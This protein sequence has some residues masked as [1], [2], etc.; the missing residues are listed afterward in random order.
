MITTLALPVFALASLPI[1][2]ESPSPAEPSPKV[3][4][5]IKAEN[6]LAI[7][8]YRLLDDGPGNLVCSP[9]SVARVLGMLRE[10][11]EGATAQE[12]E[13]LLA[14]APNDGPD[15]FRALNATI[16]PP[17]AHKRDAGPAYA[18]ESGAA[19][20]VDQR[21]ELVPDG[22]ERLRSGFDSRAETV[23]FRSP[24]VVRGAVND[25][26]REL[27]HGHVPE[28]L[29]PDL[30]PEDGRAILTDAV[31]FRASWSDPFKTEATQPAPFLR[32][33]ATPVDVP[34][35]RRTGDMPYAETE[36]AQVVAIPFQRALVDLIVVLP[37]QGV[38]LGDVAAHEDFT[39]WTG[40]L[41][42]TKVALKL[43][44]FAARMQK[45][46]KV[47]LQTLGVQAAF[48]PAKS[49]FTRLVSNEPLVI[50]AV[51]HGAR[52]VVDENGA[53]AAAA[54]AAVMKVGSAAKPVEPKPFVADHPF[55]FAIRHRSSGSVIF[56]GRVADP[57][58]E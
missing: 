13:T 1:L 32:E 36:R 27:T 54:T 53:E 30:P 16:A 39:A 17:P 15:V 3:A 5:L 51:I 33:S 2:I 31:W 14:L 34:M 23:D 46:L 37:K 38:T 21:L 42:R 29:P 10:A 52:I 43:P 6:Q 7:G 12:I 45:D 22:L 50:D 41:E 56:L 35:M 28:L 44:R 25:W 49:R 58:V 26:A 47:P 57:S 20:W 18:L 40:K 19:L 48:D 4:A 9:T 11:A 55:L 8:L 24:K